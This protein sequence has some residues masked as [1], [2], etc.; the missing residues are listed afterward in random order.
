MADCDV[1]FHTAAY[2]RENYKGGV[3]W[4]Q[5]KRINVD[6][7]QALLAHAYAAGIRRFVQTSSIAVLDGKPGQW[8]DETQSRALADADDYYRSKILADQKVCAFLQQ[9]ADMRACFVLPGWMWGPADIGP[10]SSGQLLLD[11]VRG[12]LPGLVPGSFSVVDARDVAQAQIAAAVVGRNG[13]RYLAA[14]QHMTMRDL[15]PLLAQVAQV[16]APTRALP[17]PLLWVLASLQEVY[18]RISG[19]P[20][21]LSLSTVRLML[22]EAERTRFNPAK[23]E[24]EL[25][26]RFRPV[27]ET[28]RDT[29][30]WY[31]Q[32]G[33]LSAA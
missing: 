12:K 2:F 25:G 15:V 6:G 21:L 7:T 3:H 24:Q 1:V 9:H 8:I 11:V 17:V 30:A 29:F 28:L 16:K 4:A 20:I 18:S 33:W 19:R 14:G 13:E 27:E 22:R 32:H 31:Q 5:L 26:L 23:S 10:T